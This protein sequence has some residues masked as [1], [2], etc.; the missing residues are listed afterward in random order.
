M[1]I[2][3]YIYEIPALKLEKDV[4]S[5]PDTAYNQISKRKENI[6]TEMTIIHSVD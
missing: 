4:Q 6:A 3:I 5:E 2:D 1:V